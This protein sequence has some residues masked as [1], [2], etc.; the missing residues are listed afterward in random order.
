MGNR[1]FFLRKGIRS[2]FDPT[3]PQENWPTRSSDTFDQGVNRWHVG[4]FRLTVPSNP[5]VP[6]TK[7]VERFT[8]LVEQFWGRAARASK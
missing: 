1:I 7:F 2:H 8:F 6:F 5:D 3:R 4:G